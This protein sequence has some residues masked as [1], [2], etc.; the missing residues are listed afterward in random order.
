MDTIS[1]T[2]D[3]VDA[4]INSNTAFTT[5][6]NNDSAIAK[7]V[8]GVSGLNPSNFTGKAGLASNSTAMDSVADSDKARGIIDGDITP[9]GHSTF[10]STIT[11]TSLAVAKYASALVLDHTT[12]N[13]MADLVSS[14]SKFQSVAG[15]NSAMEYITDSPIALSEVNKVQDA[16]QN[17]D[18]RGGT[19]IQNWADDSENIIGGNTI[20]FNTDGTFDRSNYSSLAG[21]VVELNGA[22]G[23][24][25]GGDG[26]GDFNTSGGPG[27]TGGDTQFL[28]N[29]AEG[30]GIT[31]VFNAP[32]D[33]SHS[34]G[35]QSSGSNSVT[36]EQSTGGGS[37]GGTG[38]SGSPNRDDGGDGFDGGFIRVI[39][40]EESLPSTVSVTVG[41]GGDGGTAGQ[42]SD[43]TAQDGFPGSSG[44]AIVT[45]LLE[46]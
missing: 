11:S 14:S 26:N 4:V 34:P 38:G 36:V 37:F 16:V 18:N 10:Y 23:G 28:G 21:V 29:T 30:G 46:Q 5:V 25:Q 15:D 3:S 43:G 31:D 17:V 45:P 41:Q 32:D 8:A 2:T 1:I 44:S 40:P 7:F 9:I 39:V 12:V 19:S 22:G 13:G 24:G 20:S 33:A 6:N 35:G 27:E 42:D